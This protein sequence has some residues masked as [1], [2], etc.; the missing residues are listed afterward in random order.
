VTLQNRQS[1]D[2]GLLSPRA[3]ALGP[4]ARARL[5]SPLLAVLIGAL[6]GAL[7][8]GSAVSLVH[9]VYNRLASVRDALAMGVFFTL[10]WGL[11]AAA[12]TTFG[13]LVQRMIA[14]DR[15]R[16]AR[17]S[18]AA[19]RS[20]LAWGLSCFHIGFFV[21]FVVYGRTYDEVAFA[22]PPSTVGGMIALLAMGGV[23]VAVVVT[24]LSRAIARALASLTARGSLRRT[25]ATAAVASLV[26]HGAAAIAF[27][28]LP[29]PAPPAASSF[30]PLRAGDRA[31]KRV[32][33]VGLDGADW[34]VLR[35]LVERGETPAFARM[36]K[37]GAW[38]S[39]RSLPGYNSA[40]IWA[41]IFTGKSPRRH[42]VLDFYRTRLPGMSGPGIYPVHRSFFIETGDL[43][44]KRGVMIT[45]RIVDRSFLRTRPLWEILDDLGASVGIVDGYQISVPAR[46]L[47]TPGGFF[48]SYALNAVAARPDFDPTKIAPELLELL[49]QPPDAV[50]FYAPHSALPDFDWQAAT[51]LDVLGAQQQPEFVSLYGHQPDAVQHDRWKWYQPELFLR[52]DPADVERFGDDIPR[53]YRDIDRVLGALMERLAPGTTLMVVSDHG[54]SP[55]PNDRLYSQ[56]RHGPPGIVL[57]WGDTVRSGFELPDA[58][59]YDVTPTVLHLL[60]FPVGADMAGRALTE[61]FEPAAPGAA[62]P[63]T[64]ESYDAFGAAS[65]EGSTGPDLSAEEIERLRALG[66]L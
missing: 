53:C 13:A 56:H 34:R 15:N 23:A 55:T 12:A 51:L 39:L 28:L 21:P 8:F 24:L 19:L 27:A 43:L 46:P 59:V 38:G 31:G 20:R 18:S 65:F 36:M 48:F 50:R 37:E 4:A 9:L 10:L 42:Q 62:A 40:A 29:E 58:S 32:V 26:L 61:A 35:P 3:T 7:V 33:L 17:D 30:R 11:A 16:G 54:H 49:V 63:R 2:D 47:Q 6:W 64:I 52:V 14:R 66:Y 45:R 57:L 5:A 41:S 44:A 25:T 22:G 1:R 60:G